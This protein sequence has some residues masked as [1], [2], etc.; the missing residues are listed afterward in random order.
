MLKILIADDHV[1]AQLGLEILIRGVIREECQFDFAKNGKEILRALATKNYDILVTDLNMPDTDIMVLL[2]Q[3][4]Q[5]QPNL[6]TMV[7]SV[8]S[9]VVFSKRCLQLGAYAYVPKS[10][11]DQEIKLAIQ[12]ILLG[13]KY[14]SS[15]Q[16]EFFITE[17]KNVTN[18]FELLSVRELDVTILLLKGLGIIEIANSLKINP[19]TAS[20]FKS[21][22]FDKL[23]VKNMV[24]LI[25]LSRQF[26]IIEDVELI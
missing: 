21:R 2:P 19:S 18:P 5:T 14:I 10:A 7:V 13:K 24:E 3:L 25:K 16:A 23:Q 9:E 11:T 6:R 20:T 22:I 4:L 26:R 8:G 1:A 15:A 12:S 17:R